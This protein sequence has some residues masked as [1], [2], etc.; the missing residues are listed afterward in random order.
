MDSLDGSDMFFL[1]VG[2]I[3]HLLIR[4]GNETLDLQCC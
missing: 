1:I 4:C 2:S 3:Y